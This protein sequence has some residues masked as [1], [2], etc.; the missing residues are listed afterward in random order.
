MERHAHH[1]ENGAA[2]TALVLILPVVLLAV[3]LV[4]QL[5]L[6]FHARQVVTAAAQDAALAA[7]AQGAATDTA[8]T[9][10]RHVLDSAGRGLLHDQTVAA[11]ADGDRVHVTVTGTVA[12][13]VPG[14][15][16]TV[17]GTSDSPVERVRPQEPAP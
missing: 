10:A 8:D 1:G 13:V 2:T 16:L 14:L 9:T 7:T 12:S 11:T 15:E 4:V 6:A 17:T 5:A 3:M